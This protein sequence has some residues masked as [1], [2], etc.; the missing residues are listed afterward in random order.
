LQTSETVQVGTGDRGQRVARIA[1][2]RGRLVTSLLQEA[3]G[4]GVGSVGENGSD[5]EGR[6]FEKGVRLM[7][8]G[9]VAK[10]LRVCTA[11]VYA[12]I[13]RGELEHVRVSNVIRVVVRLPRRDS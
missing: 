7:T 4:K 2:I 9:E 5:A 8:V 11:T 3:A 6:G 1:S 12:M 10:A 13:E